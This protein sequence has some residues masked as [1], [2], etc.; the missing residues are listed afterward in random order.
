MF[1]TTKWNSGS[2]A[3]VVIDLWIN[4]KEID[5]VAYHYVG[6]INLVK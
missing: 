3:D 1:H 6:K 5:G 4:T 2:F